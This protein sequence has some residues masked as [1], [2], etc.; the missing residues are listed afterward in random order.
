MG[1]KFAKSSD[2]R[3]QPI[4][5]IREEP[6]WM[7]MASI[8]HH[9]MNVKIPWCKRSGS[10]N[11]CVACY[12]RVSSWQST[13]CFYSPNYF[14]IN[15]FMV[16]HSSFSI[17][18]PNY[19][20]TLASICLGLKALLLLLLYHIWWFVVIFSYFFWR[21]QDFS[22]PCNNILCDFWT[23]TRLDFLGLN[24]SELIWYSQFWY[25][26]WVCGRLVRF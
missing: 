4:A 19:P 6:P 15:R 13:D 2:C 22:T 9:A 5:Y 18:V 23:S 17:S 21:T 3:T 11:L 26:I 12:V 10:F 8:F 25:L 16:S 1:R 20:L 14:S 7:Q 24:T